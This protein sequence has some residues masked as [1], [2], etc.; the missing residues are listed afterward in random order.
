M[1]LVAGLGNPTG[2]Y[3]HTRHNAGFD[4][5]DI[6]SAKLGIKVNRLFSQ[7]LTG[8]GMLETEKIILAKPQTYMNLSGQAVCQLLQYYKIGPENLIVI[9]D[10]SDLDVGRLRIRKSGSAGGHNGMKDI[11]ERI[12][13]QD[14]TRVRVGIGHRPPY[15]DMVDF[16]LGRPALE[17]QKL[18]EETF[19]KASLA[20][21]DIIL[22]GAEHAMNQYNG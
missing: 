2:K 5:L 7:A 22:N 12:G 14:F 20:V 16:V 21:Q 13:T 6:L 9:Y 18:L 11:I 19:E 15:M 4:S 3:E 17:E 1:F 8:K 10:D